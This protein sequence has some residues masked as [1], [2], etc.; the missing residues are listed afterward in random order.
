MYEELSQAHHNMTTFILICNSIES[1]LFLRSNNETDKLKVKF[2]Q[3]TLFTNN[4][5]CVKDLI[6]WQ[7][8]RWQQTC[9]PFSLD[10]W[11][12][13]FIYQEK[14]NITVVLRSKF[15]EIDGKD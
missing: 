13:T 7:S 2:S 5:H 11:P 6:P 9:S 12:E 10:Q 15:Q 3:L 1:K 8:C 14:A 4:L